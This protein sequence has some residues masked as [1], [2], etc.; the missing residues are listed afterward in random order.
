MPCSRTA[1]IVRFN[2]LVGRARFP[3]IGAL[4]ILKGSILLEENRLAEAE[5]ELTQG[6]SL[7]R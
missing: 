5:A 4:H 6:L 3:P 7:I 2:R 1:N